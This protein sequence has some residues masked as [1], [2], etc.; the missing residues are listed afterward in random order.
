MLKWLKAL[1]V[2]ALLSIPSVVL[3]SDQSGGPHEIAVN[4]TDQ[5]LNAADETSTVLSAVPFAE[6]TVFVSGTYGNANV[7]MIG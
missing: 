2:A 6:L 7:G 4:T 3:A 1:G 5:L